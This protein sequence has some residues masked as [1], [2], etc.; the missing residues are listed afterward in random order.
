M[1]F[2]FFSCPADEFFIILE[3][4]RVESLRWPHVMRYEIPSPSCFLCLG[5]N[6][7]HRPVKKHE[8]QCSE[9][10]EKQAQKILWKRSEK[11]P[12]AFLLQI[13]G[14]G[15]VDLCISLRCHHSHLPEFCSCFQQVHVGFVKNTISC[16]L[17]LLFI[18][19]PLLPERKPEQ[20]RWVWKQDRTI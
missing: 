5:Q 9:R 3:T 8:V 20:E 2:F 14:G 17:C 6:I 13:T 12:K 4:V 1:D 11:Y 19:K 10:Q 7:S 15:L 18:L 16:K